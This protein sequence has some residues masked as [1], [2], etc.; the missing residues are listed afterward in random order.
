L[1]CGRRKRLLSG[2]S[3]VFVWILVWQLASARIG[4]EMLLP[5]PSSVLQR[6][7]SLALTADYWAGV[8]FTFAHVA[9]GF[10]SAFCA[11][12]VL[13]ASACAC[14]LLRSLIE[15]L[16]RVMKAAPVVSY[17][18]LCLLLLPSTWL[19]AAISFV[20]ALPI[21]YTNM[22][23]GLDAVDRNLLEMAAVFA[24]RPYKR[25]FFIVFPQMAP[26]LLS[27]TSLALGLCLKAGVA[28][29]VIGLPRGSVGEQMYQAKVFVD[30]GG[31]LAWTATVVALSFLL[32]KASAAVFDALLKSLERM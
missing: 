15:P 29:E 6:L 27:G 14:H 26:F 23:A 20:M 22:L 17:I 19:S 7:C 2:A 30:S 5:S 28:A 18:I 24:V 3:V 1:T 11:G 4:M 10:V 21:L 31:V 25:A 9:L 16:M 13:S 12:M 32:E 8:G